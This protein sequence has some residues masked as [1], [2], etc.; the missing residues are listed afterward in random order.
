MK[1][2]VILFIDLYKLVF[3]NTLVFLFGG[4][5]RFT[6]TCSEYSK[7]AVKRH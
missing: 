6:P 4:G 2:I 3:S 1:K 5:C 7:E